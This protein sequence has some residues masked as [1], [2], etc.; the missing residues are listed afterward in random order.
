MIN[1]GS[2]GIETP[3]PKRVVYKSRKIN[4]CLMESLAYPRWMAATRIDFRLCPHRGYFDDSDQRCRDC[5]KEIECRWVNTYNGRAYPSDMSA[6]ELI[7]ALDIAIGFVDHHKATP[8]S[9][10]L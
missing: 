8:R 2:W 4:Q 7:E 5:S 3:S 1:E 9:S 6:G 10:P